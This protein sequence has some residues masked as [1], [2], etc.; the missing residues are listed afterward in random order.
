MI[1]LGEETVVVR[2]APLATDG[3]YG[4]ARR[5]WDQ[6]TDT[7]VAGVAMQPLA[8]E[9]ND[10]DRERT[11]SRMRLYLPPAGAALAAESRVVWRGTTYEVDGSPEPWYD[12]GALDHLAAT[13]KLLAG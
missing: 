8:Y 13:V 4:N 10:V 9:E 1:A 11:V 12:G 2:N 3:R 6:A 7:T 5:D